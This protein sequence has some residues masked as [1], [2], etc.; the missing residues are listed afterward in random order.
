MSKMSIQE[1]KR[2]KQR[3]LMIRKMT[4]IG[5]ISAFVILLGVFLVR[6]VILPLMGRSGGSKAKPEEVAYGEI[7]EDGSITYEMEKGDMAERIP[8]FSDNDTAKAAD[9]TPG[10]HD[11]SYGRWYRNPDGT[12]YANGFQE[13]DGAQYS[14]DGDGYVQTGW[15]T[16]GVNDYYFNEDGSYNPDKK[17]P[18]LALTFDD[19]PGQYTMELLECLEANGAHATFF[20]LGELVGSYPDEVRKMVEIGCELGNHSYDHSDQTTLSLD[21]VYKQFNDTDQNLINACGQAATVA[22]APYG[23]GN[24]DIYQTVGKPFFMWSLDTMDWSLLDADADYN[25]VMNGDLTDG[26]IILMHDIHQPSVQAALRIIPDLV[27]QGYKLVTVSEM[28]EAKGVDLQNTCYVDFWQSTLDAGQVPGYTGQPDLLSGGSSDSST[29]L[30]SEELSSGA[31]ETLESGSE[32]LSG[33]EELYGGDDLSGGDGSLSEEEP[34]EVVT[35]EYYED[36]GELGEY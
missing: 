35:E 10:W 23:N 31:E 11:N 17:K 8:V 1:R 36:S 27:A 21:E 14:F 30:G 24:A 28:A 19:G 16:R 6:G 26:T 2:I 15:I 33:E 25:S 5:I 34:F 18:M 29:D 22:R 12:F 32:D 3:Q 7:N 4:R 20:M 9:L 13:I